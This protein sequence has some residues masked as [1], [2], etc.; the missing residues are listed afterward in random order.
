[1]KRARRYIRPILRL[2]AFVGCLCAVLL[3]LD[4]RAARASV[5]E[6]L[7]GIGQRMAP[8]MDDGR[9]TEGPRQVRINGVRVF[10]AA[11]HTEHPAAWVRKW[12]VDR[13][14]A[15][16]D[17][18]AMVGDELKKKGA[19][20][21]DAPALNQLVF[22]NDKAGGMAALDFG[23]KL[24][25]EGLKDRFARFLGSGQLGSIARLRYVYFEK[26]NVG[27]RFLTVWTDDKFELD[28]LIPG[29]NRDAD[30][31][32]VTDVPRYPGTV[33]CLSAEEHG[34]P[35]K[36]VVYDGPGTPDT[37]E[38]FYRARM[39][40]LGWQID[41]SFASVAKKQ[42]KTAL[43]FENKSGHEVIIDLSASENQDLTVCVIQ[44]R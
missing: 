39:K 6:R 17:G 11:G 12:Y 1:M 32:D 8:Y 44:T 40:T 16:D 20:P 15:K 24:S 43:R 35:Q 36:L 34:M 7:L 3:Y 13:Y 23:D 2:A 30:G 28:K 41:E 9:S 14:A 22:G 26:A 29:E 25:L 33:R 18:L 31:S 27:T 37:A 38:L 19:L 4:Y 42:N 21:P 10:V 5:M